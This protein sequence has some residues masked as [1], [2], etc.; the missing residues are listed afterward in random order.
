MG[1]IK[2]VQL[3]DTD[4][5]DL[6]ILLADLHA[7]LDNL[8]STPDLIKSRTEFY[9][10]ILS[11]IMKRVRS[12][13]SPGGESKEPMIVIGSSFQKSPDYIMDLY[14]MM[15][16]T[17]AKN[18]QRAGAEVVKQSKDPLLSSMV[19]PLMQCLDEEYLK[20][21]V[22]F[23]GIDQRKLFMFSRDNINSLGY[24][25]RMYLMNPLIPGL[26]KSGK[27]SSSEPLS[28]I[29]FDDSDE[30]IFDKIKKAY[31]IDG[32]IEGNGLLAIAKYIV[33]ELFPGGILITREEKYGG[34][35][36]YATYT[37]LENDFKNGKLASGDL[38]PSLARLISEIIGPIR[39]EL[40]Q[41]SD[42]IKRAYM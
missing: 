9:Q 1:V 40:N 33:F 35:I 38:K 19:Y 25:K 31:S 34:D 39:E 21:D 15:S 41:Y 36:G 5:V 22:Q 11:I 7:M 37:D 23:G 27:M 13:I 12:F 42:L 10:V 6:T 18:A 32:V 2:L 14:R 3:V 28:K 8:K 17:S 16:I 4:R 24:D 30:V 20:C 26:T 29:D